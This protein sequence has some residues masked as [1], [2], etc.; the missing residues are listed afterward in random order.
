MSVF[1]ISLSHIDFL[2]AIISLAYI[3]FL[4]AT[5]Q[6]EASQFHL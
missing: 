2:T 5:L 3:L 4:A 6:D 1:T